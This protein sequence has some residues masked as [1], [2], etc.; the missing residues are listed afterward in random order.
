MYK[1]SENKNAV[2]QVTWLRPDITRMFY[3]ICF[4][5]IMEVLPILYLTALVCYSCKP[6][7]KD[8]N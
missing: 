6:V 8:R 3:E 1:D 7:R 5:F 2:Y 4:T